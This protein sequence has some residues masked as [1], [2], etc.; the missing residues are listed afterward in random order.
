MGLHKLLDN[1]QTKVSV[2]VFV[3]L[4]F[5]KTSVKIIYLF[6]YLYIDTYS[7]TKATFGSQ[8]LNLYFMVVGRG[9]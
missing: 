2:T 6:K 4:L 3:F 9:L 5:Y 8:L 1:I 7:Y